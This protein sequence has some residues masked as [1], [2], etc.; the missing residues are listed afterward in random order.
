MAEP[1]AELDVGRLRALGEHLGE[2]PERIAATL[3]AELVRSLA[4]IDAGLDAGDVGAVAQGAHAARNSALMI[5]AAPTLAA[6]DALERAARAG[7]LAAARTARERLG[8]RWATLRRRLQRAAD[9]HP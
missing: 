3:H 2:P 8:G 5:D 7:D 4:E 9:E 1:D 6:L